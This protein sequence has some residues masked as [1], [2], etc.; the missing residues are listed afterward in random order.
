MSKFEEF[1]NKNKNTIHFFGI[2]TALI[3]LIF[4]CNNTRQTKKSIEL[5]YKQYEE[6]VS[7]IWKISV[8]NETNNIDY[9]K[10]RIV[11]NNN[12]IVL[13][14]AEIFFGI[15]EKLDSLIILKPEN[16]NTNYLK[17]QIL[18]DIENYYLGDQYFWSFYS[19]VPV[20]VKFSYYQHGQAKIIKAFYK[21]NIRI[22]LKNE[23]TKI[24][25]KSFEFLRYI[26]N[27][28]STKVLEEL[29][30]FNYNYCYKSCCKES[31]LLKEKR[32][33]IEN[34]KYLKDFLDYSRKF[35]LY[36]NLSIIVQNDTSL[37]TQIVFPK[38]IVNDSLF[39]EIKSK[40]EF[41]ISKRRFYP[42][43]VYKSFLNLKNYLDTVEFPE[44]NDYNEIIKTK[45][46][47]ERKESLSNYHKAM[48]DSLYSSIKIE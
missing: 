20:C 39:S 6:M 45:W 44:K 12:L 24:S 43:S 5:S 16:W 46:N 48:I 42:K 9:E 38:F 36:I 32:N 7:P 13:N 17:R 3:T 10:L 34:D 21:L 26:N 2:I 4:T 27:L 23:T 1:L 14:S 41:I 47:K 28:T 25:F 40:Q 35:Q 19:C 11:S 29:E 33:L 37:N 15:N 18:I 8:I 22:Y 31:F 30:E